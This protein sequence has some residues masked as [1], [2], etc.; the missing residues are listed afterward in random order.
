VVVRGLFLE[1]TKRCC[2]SCERID[3]IIPGAPVVAVW[4]MG[5]SLRRIQLGSGDCCDVREVS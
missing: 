5:T 4:S 1:A 2:P 3:S